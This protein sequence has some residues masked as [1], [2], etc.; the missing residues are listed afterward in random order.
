MLI[1]SQTLYLTRSAPTGYSAAPTDTPPAGSESTGT[2]T[3]K[4]TSTV[5]NYVTVYPVSSGSAAGPTGAYGASQAGYASLGS[6]VP[7][8]TVTV[9]EKETITVTVGTTSSTSTGA[10]VSP[11][12]SSSSAYYPT[13]AYPSSSGVA[14]S[15]T[16]LSTAFITIHKPKPTGY[17]SS[18]FPVAPISTGSV[19]SSYSASS[20]VAP[21]SKSTSSA[22][23]APTGY[24]KP[25]GYWS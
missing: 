3:L 22:S 8:T 5:T 24:A 23:A 17:S 6:C 14:S 15:S 12:Q 21:V 4:S 10:V 1:L 18:G 2:E 11:I 16:C 7:G 13:S 20:P 9:T 25:T 19:P